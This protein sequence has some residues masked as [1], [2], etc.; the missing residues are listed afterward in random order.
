MK[1]IFF[2]LIA[3]S[4]ALSAIGQTTA[5]TP[6][7]T[8]TP[9]METTVTGHSHLVD[10]NRPKFSADSILAPW[11]VDVNLLA[12][13]LTQ[14]MTT[15][16]TAANYTNG[17]NLNTGSLKFTNGMSFG[18]DVQLGYFFGKK[19]HWGIGTGFM[20]LYQ[21]GDATLDNYHVEYQSTDVRGDIYRQVTTATQPIKEA[22]QITNMN[23]PLVL[24]Y[25]NRF[26]RTLGFTAD[27]GLLFNI[28]TTNAYKTNASFNYEA[29]YKRSSDGSFVYDNAATPDVNDI[30][31]TQ[32]QLN[33]T[34]PAGSD[35][36]S[37]FSFLRNTLGYNVGL[38]NKA[39][40]DHG[41]VSYTTGS[42]GFMLQPSLN[43]FL[44]DDVALNFGLYYIYQSFSNSVKDG[45]R[46]TDR[47]GDYSSVLNSVSSVSSQSY[48][49]NVGVRF[50]FGRKGPVVS[51]E[52]AYNPSLCGLSDGRILINGLHPEDSA[53]VSYAYNGVPQTPIRT[54]TDSDGTITLNNLSEGKYD[55]IHVTMRKRNASGMPV[56]LSNPP[57]T[58]TF[59]SSTNPTEYKKCDGTITLNIPRP[60]QS[61]TI[62]YTVDGASKSSTATIASNNRIVL[63]GLCGGTYT[64]IT[65]VMGKCSANAVDVTLVDPPAPPP[66]PPPAPS[67]PPITVSTPI[68]FEVNKTVIREDSHPII[69]M[70]VDKLNSDKDAIVV[71]NGYADITGKP[72][73][74]KA[75]SLRRANAVKKEL[76]KLG[77]SPKRIKVVGHGS[78]DP[79]GNNDTEEGRALNRR[80]VMHLNIGE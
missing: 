10:P 69:V 2:L 78:N 34:L 8:P 21:Q 29:I 32:A 75:L 13:M 5:T 20:Y 40:T 6:A 57:F 54:M 60:G 77:I 47:V 36:N 18:G 51:S 12:G 62:N 15:K 48:G 65:A 4:G 38:G 61:V 33:R 55:T 14:D 42:V 45:Y 58:I 44:S 70:A 43:V 9:P 31:F 56:T 24:K 79:A 64:N 80:A 27:A 11:V 66:P 1:R 7:A 76:V 22:L 23:I 59:E 46:T 25:K 41:S 19:R 26:S 68:L 67:A 30:L 17:V 3:A 71:I 73:Y 39:A 16:N 52:D 63:N 37:Y 28:Q 50:L 74:N 49:L 35:I 53:V 72:A